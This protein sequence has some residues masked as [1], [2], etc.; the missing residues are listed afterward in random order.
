M[1]VIILLA[2]WLM[3]GCAPKADD[4]PTSPKTFASSTWVSPGNP[5]WSFTFDGASTIDW[6][7]GTGGKCQSHVVLTWLQD[8]DSGTMTVSAS[9]ALITVSGMPACS[10]F[11]GNWTYSILEDQALILCPTVGGCVEF[12]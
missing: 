3:T 1:V 6:V 11:D 10:Q 5:N 2:L 4:Q 7:Y 8:Q 9:T 12:H